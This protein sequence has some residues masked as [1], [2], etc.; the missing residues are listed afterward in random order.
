MLD[1]TA[2][3]CC[4]LYMWRSQG[5]GCTHNDDKGRNMNEAVVKATDDDVT[6]IERRVKKERRRGEERRD[7]GF[8][9]FNGVARR[10]TL[11]RRK[12]TRDRRQPA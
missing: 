9:S 1:Y 7:R 8:S 4:C 3:P 2:E 10:M 6:M 12:C 11:D 5:I